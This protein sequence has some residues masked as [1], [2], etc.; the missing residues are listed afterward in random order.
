MDNNSVFDIR[1]YLAA[2]IA[3]NDKAYAKAR[4]LYCERIADC[5]STL[6]SSALAEH[7]YIVSCPIEVHIK[8][9]QALAVLLTYPEE[10]AYNLVRQGW[11]GLCQ[12]IEKGIRGIEMYILNS[13]SDAVALDRL[14]VAILVYMKLERQI[15]PG[16]HKAFSDL[17]R[18]YEEEPEPIT[19][20][21]R[22]R[23]AFPKNGHTGID[24]LGVCTDGYGILDALLDL[25]SEM[26]FSLSDY[27]SGAQLS[28]ELKTVCAE[29]AGDDTEFLP[30][31]GLM[32]LMIETVKQD[33][34]YL[35]SQDADSYAAEAARLRAELG[36]LKRELDSLKLSLA[37]AESKLNEAN[38]H[39]SRLVAVN[40]RFSAQLDQYE[41][42]RQE[43][44]ALRDALRLSAVPYEEPKPE[45]ETRHLPEDIR[46]V[47]IGGH[48]RWITA[49]KQLLPLIYI[50]ADV[51]PD[52]AV[53]RSASAV[54]F[55]AEYMS[56][57]QFV[58]VIECCRANRIPVYYFSGS[59]ADRCAREILERHGI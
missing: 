41:A 47:C 57:K 23:E 2:A 31:L 17:A 32:A 36:S 19:D 1:P 11:I 37:N 24:G 38:E 42:L 50:P 54:W 59:G 40:F 33:K 9:R 28:D 12:R 53:I 8:A 30:A 21:S 20:I 43:C 26:R 13:S 18:V 45:A 49:M 7:V 22:G 25:G 10:T 4:Q 29:I 15:P 52:M 3:R 48:D 44:A 46:I 51:T 55:F 27:V 5:E 56:H 14:A 6:G 16:I 39:M 58:P 35:M 34:E